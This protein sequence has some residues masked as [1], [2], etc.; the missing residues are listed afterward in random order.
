MPL[1][2]ETGL[3]E[4]ACKIVELLA[5]KQEHVSQ[6]PDQIAAEESN[7]GDGL[8]AQYFLLRVALVGICTA[9]N[10]TRLT[11]AG[12]EARTS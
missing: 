6:I 3:L 10:G 7:V 1:F 2:I 9:L 5:S 12:V 8:K 4:I 11:N